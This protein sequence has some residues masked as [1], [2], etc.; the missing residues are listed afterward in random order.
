[1]SV[2]HVNL[3]EVRATGSS[4]NRMHG[5]VGSLVSS[6]KSQMG[7]LQQQFQGARAAK[8]MGQWEEMQPSLDA[9]MRTMEAAG[10]LLTRAADD[11]EAVDMR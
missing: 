4:F 3:D 8:I 5:E 11:F 10:Q 7:N 1:M 9:A 6:A 2:I